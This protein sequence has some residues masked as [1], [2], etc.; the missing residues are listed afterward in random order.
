MAMYRVEDDGHVVFP[1]RPADDITDQLFHGPGM[2]AAVPQVDGVVM[3]PGKAEGIV[4]P[5]EAVNTGCSI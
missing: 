2:A 3:I 5:A 1:G 4:D